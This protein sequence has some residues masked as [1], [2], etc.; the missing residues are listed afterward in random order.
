MTAQGALGQCRQAQG[1]GRWT[2]IKD[3]TLK[4]LLLEQER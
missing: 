1:K 2:G 3:L 4:Q